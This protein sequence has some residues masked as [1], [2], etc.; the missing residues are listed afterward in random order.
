M[1]PTLT[2]H[3]DCGTDIDASP[4]DRLHACP[5]CESAFACKLIELSGET[6]I[7]PFANGVRTVRG[8]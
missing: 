3:C 2:I 8:P 7:L 4:T 6:E 5:N 1:P